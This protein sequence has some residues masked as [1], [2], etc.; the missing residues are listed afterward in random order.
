MNSPKTK[1]RRDYIA[2][3]IHKPGA[4]VLPT[5]LSMWQRLT[6]NDAI[7]R[8]FMLLVLAIVWEL[9]AR[10]LNNSL[11]IPT[12]SS[13]ITAL[14]NSIANGVMLH[15]I[16]NSITMLLEAYAIGVVIAT[17]MT[18]LAVTTRF[19]SD[20]LTTLTAMFNP[21]PAIALLPLAL[22]WFGLGNGSMIFVV[23]HSVL[24]PLAMNVHSGYKGVSETLRMAGRNP[25]L[26]PISYV[27][28]VLFP[29]AMPAVISG[30]KVSW[31]FGWRTL[32]A[33]ELV[34]G[35]SS[36]GGGIGWFIFEKRNDLEIP[37]VF[38][39]LLVI[40][41]IGLAVEGFVFRELELRTVQRWG[42]VRG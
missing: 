30:L 20:L 4:I 29:A 39:G 24:W 42:M 32:I 19:G 36:S 35:A 34:F 18:T 9:Y 7:R 23:A 8:A 15:R 16:L 37:D 21:L 3:R 12:L 22:L 13:V 25:G 11:M 2:E 40:V 27:A 1:E 17:F 33:A 38:A 26:K 5:R 10:W 28:R 6:R 14:A 41:L 31:A